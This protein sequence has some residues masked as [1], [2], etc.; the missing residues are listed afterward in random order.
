MQD[1]IENIIYTE[2]SSIQV[3][4]KNKKNIFREQN[5]KNALSI[6]KQDYEQNQK[7]ALSIWKQDY[8]E[9][10]KDALSIWKQDY[11]QNQKDALSI[12]RQDYDYDYDYFRFYKAPS[13]T[14]CC[15]TT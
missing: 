5:Q 14:I 3:R 11:E 2:L 9:N 6:W 10:Q 13:A 12:W 8:E 15:Y 7:D 4:D 1:I